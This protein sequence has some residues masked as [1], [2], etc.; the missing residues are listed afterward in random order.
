MVVATRGE[1][2]REEGS[3]ASARCFF[4]AN[5]TGRGTIIVPDNDL[6]RA[7]SNSP[8]S[9]IPFL[10]F[11][12]FYLHPEERWT[13]VDPS[14]SLPFEKTKRKKVSTTVSPEGKERRRF[15]LKRGWREGGKNISSEVKFAAGS[16]SAL[17]YRGTPGTFDSATHTRTLSFAPPPNLHRIYIRLRRDAG[18]KVASERKRE[19]ERDSIA[20]RTRPFEGQGRSLRHSSRLASTFDRSRLYTSTPRREREKGERNVGDQEGGYV[21]SWTDFP[22]RG[23]SKERTPTRPS[24]PR[25]FLRMSAQGKPRRVRVIGAVTSELNIIFS[26]E[27]RPLNLAGRVCAR[28]YVRV[29]GPIIAATWCRTDCTPSL[30]MFA[31]RPTV[32]PISPSTG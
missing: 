31:R 8:R 29:I 32:R 26:D 13:K 25:D 20:N 4:A 5:S 24:I 30:L 11:F 2:R 23:E 19:R 27:W 9:R 18:L 16:S 3:R 1:K 10:L 6:I 12:F 22:S 14:L 7:S 21:S 15:R 28:A 17:V